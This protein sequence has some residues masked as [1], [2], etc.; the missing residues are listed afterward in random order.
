MPELGPHLRLGASTVLR[1]SKPC[2]RCPAVT[3][4]PVTGV[5]RPDG[6]PLRTLKSVEHRLVKEASRR[7]VL[8]TSP[9]FAVNF[10]LQTPGDVQVGDGVF[11]LKEQ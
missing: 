4:N 5:M 9:I 10:S 8:G 2:T 7:K 3:V 6:E 1:F 11:V